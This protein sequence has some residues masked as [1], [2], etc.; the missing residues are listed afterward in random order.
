MSD[1]PSL[2]IRP[3]FATDIRR[4]FLK[5]LSALKPCELSEER[6]IWVYR[7][8]LRQKI[9]TYV[10]LLDGEIVGTASLIIEPK[11][12]ND[13]GIVG[14]IEDVAVRN[15]TQLHGIGGQLVRHLLEVSRREGCYKVILDCAD[16]VVPFYE[17]LGFHRWEQAMRI[18]LPRE[19]IPASSD[20]E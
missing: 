10:A 14:H 15:D 5:T 4:G 13:G 20:K 12:I 19:G 8:R 2:T 7:R 11:F 3:M 18:D 16:H 6:A 9:Q 17:K 1:S